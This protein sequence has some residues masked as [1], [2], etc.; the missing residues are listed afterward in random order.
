MSE[1]SAKNGTTGDAADSTPEELRAE[2]E[3][4]RVRLGATVE[5]LAAKADVK[6]RAQEKAEHAKVAAKLKAAAVLDQVQEKAGYAG[7]LVQDRAGRAATVVQERAGQ[8]ATVVQERTPDQ[9]RERAAVVAG[10]TRDNRNVALAV[11]GGA[12]LVAAV[13][14]RRRRRARARTAESLF[15]RRG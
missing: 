8:A 7:R 11:G 9:V 12:L 2:L 6:A 5:E 10:R 3:K 15:F 13:L 14:R 1:Q 4:K